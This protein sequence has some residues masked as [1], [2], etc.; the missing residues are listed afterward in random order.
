M[1]FLCRQIIKSAVVPI[2]QLAHQSRHIAAGNFD[3]RMPPSERVDGVGQLQNSFR[4]MQESLHRYIND[5]NQ[6]NEEIERRNEELVIA[7]EQAREADEKKTAFMQDITHQIRTPLNIII[8]FAQVLQEGGDFVSPEE[9]KLIIDAMQEN[10]YNLTGIVDML[11]T[12]SFFEEKESL[13][14]DVDFGCNEICRQVAGAVKVKA[15]EAVTLNFETTL[16]DSQKIRTNSEIFPKIIR[17]LLDNANKFTQQ[18]TITLSCD[19]KDDETLL[20]TVTDTGIG[21]PAEEKEHIFVQ[22]TKLNYYAEGIGMGLT[23]CRRGAELLGGTLELDDSYKE[24]ARFVLTMP[25]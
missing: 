20:F 4:T 14:K 5:M 3:D 24:G 1:L 10:S 16:P 25:I 7:N 17:H 11:V 15:A 2:N 6:M 13:E 9:M 19:K 8:G 18:G 22:F 12:A 23:L 21:I